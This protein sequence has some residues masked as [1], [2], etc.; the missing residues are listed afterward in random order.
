MGMENI[1][2]TVGVFD[3]GWKG[4]NNGLEIGIKIYG[5]MV[6]GSVVGEDMVLP[7]LLGLEGTSIL[8]EGT[9]PVR[10]SGRS[11]YVA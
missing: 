9:D 7:E 2:E 10:S 8:K 3:V 4:M 11:Q 6:D 5:N 1:K